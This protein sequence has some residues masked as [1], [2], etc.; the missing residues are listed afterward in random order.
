MLN[1]KSTSKHQNN[2]NYVK[3]RVELKEEL[4]LKLCV[5][6]SMWTMH[7]LHN[8]KLKINILKG[9]LVPDVLEWHR[10]C[11]PCLRKIYGHM[12]GALFSFSSVNII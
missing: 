4:E 10:K 5:N 8:C 1:L 7:T 6:P 2:E 12:A 3:G 11:C 9:I